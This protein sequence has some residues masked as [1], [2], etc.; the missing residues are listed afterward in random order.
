MDEAHS[1]GTL[2]KTGRGLSE[3]FG[4]DA[5]EIDL[6]M[7]TLSKSFGSCGGF[8]GCNGK[9]D[10]LLR[11][12]A[13]GYL[14]YST[15]ISPANTAAALAS[16]EVLEKEPNRVKKLQENA[17]LFCQKAKRAGLNIGDAMGVVPIVPVIVGDDL[18]ALKISEALSEVGILAHPILY[19][20]VERGSARIR[21]F[22]SYDHN[23]SDI[24]KVVSVLA[25][26]LN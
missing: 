15:G 16:L 1:I 4:T 22:I 7:G 18:K 12:F 23:E 3:Y 24:E 6:I 2:G 19:P 14:L 17:N 10:A 20:A 8:F 21:F 25:R 11:Y 9:F 5:R 13:P 26:E